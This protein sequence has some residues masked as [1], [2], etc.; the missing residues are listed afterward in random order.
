MA[1]DRRHP[2]M[3]ISVACQDGGLIP[4]KL[5]SKGTSLKMRRVNPGAKRFMGTSISLAMLASEVVTATA[6]YAALLLFQ[7]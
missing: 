1:I 4:P 3:T 6:I 2:K 5:R 7:K